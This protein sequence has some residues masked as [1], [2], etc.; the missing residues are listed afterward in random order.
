MNRFS[1]NALV[2]PDPGIEAQAADLN[3]RAAELIAAGRMTD[4]ERRACFTLTDLRKL[5]ESVE[6]PDPRTPEQTALDAW[7]A[8]TVATRE[9]D[10]PL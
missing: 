8:E 1:R 4:A 7:Q 6:A 2:D 9:S 5:V 10:K 3:R